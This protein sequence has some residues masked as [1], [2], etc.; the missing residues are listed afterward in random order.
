MASLLHC[1]LK[2]YAKTSW[3]QKLFQLVI[4]TRMKDDTATMKAKTIKWQNKMTQN[5]FQK[6][7]LS[8]ENKERAVTAQC[9]KKKLAAKCNKL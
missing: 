9:R 8:A 4:S 1:G 6:Y 2:C 5:P 3:A 7:S